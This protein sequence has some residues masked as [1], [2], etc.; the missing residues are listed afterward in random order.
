[1]SVPK[2]A[3]TESKLEV[4]VKAHELSCYTI[5]ITSNAKIFK[6]EFQRSLTDRITEAA[7][8]IFTLVWS[9]NN[10][11]VRDREDAQTRL[12]LQ[13]EAAVQ[14][15]VL[16]PLIEIAW[17]VFHLSSKRVR[18]WSGMVIETRNMVRAWREADAKRYREFLRGDP[19][20][21]QPI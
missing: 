17:K 4:C 2:Y 12:R 10:V 21:T 15:N 14:C 5:L 9:A 19:G 3:R 18:Y 8:E 1:M 16:L 7:I 13:A 11:L 20:E 6:P